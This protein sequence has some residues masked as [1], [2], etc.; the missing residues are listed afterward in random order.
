MNT[1]RSRLV[2]AVLLGLA[3][4]PVLSTIIFLIPL[5]M[6]TGAAV[7]L[8][9]SLAMTEFIPEEIL[10]LP[11]LGLAALISAGSIRVAII[12]HGDEGSGK[13]LTVLTNRYH[14]ESEKEY[15]E[16]QP[17]KKFVFPTEPGDEEEEKHRP[18]KKFVDDFI[19]FVTTQEDNRATVG[20]PV[21]ENY[22]WGFRVETEGFTPVWVEF[23]YGGVIDP[24][25]NTEEFEISVSP[26]HPV[27]PWKRLWYR[28]NFALRDDVER[29]LV[30]FLT[31]K[32]IGYTVE[33]EE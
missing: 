32:G 2:W 16:G 7:V 15:D 12:D 21:S 4:G 30:D 19:L 13:I 22:G 6:L 18:G 5:G 14:D 10:L 26:E 29:D 20:K 9:T 11:W 27:L 8:D 28:P 17:M 33:V 31:L 1:K 25:D 23:D 3:A 24:K